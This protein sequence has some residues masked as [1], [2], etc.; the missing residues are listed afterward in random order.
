MAPGGNFDSLHHS[1]FQ[2]AC[3]HAACIAASS[4]QLSNINESVEGV[5]LML[6]A[7]LAQNFPEFLEIL[8]P[9]CHPK[10]KTSDKS[11]T[12]YSQTGYMVDP[13]KIS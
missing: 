3:A 2:T 10:Q 12:G 1:L 4:C 7:P 8:V 13:Y 11:K 5:M 9:L 6:D